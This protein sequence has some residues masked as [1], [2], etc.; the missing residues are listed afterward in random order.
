MVTLLLLELHTPNVITSF[1]H[2]IFQSDS[3]LH[4]LISHLP[5]NVTLFVSVECARTLESVNV[6]TGV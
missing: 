3:Q 4:P 5:L 2:A 1:P 6:T